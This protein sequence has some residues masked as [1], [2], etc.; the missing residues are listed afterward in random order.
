[1]G[2]AK[3]KNALMG[4]FLALPHALLTSHRYRALS[5]SAVKLLI[6]IAMQFDGKNNGDL[7]AAWKVMKSKGWR[8]EATLDRA[9]KELL[10]LGLIAQTRQGR[11]PN[12]C[13]LY[14][15]TWLPLNPSD[16]LDIGPA[17]FSSGEWAK[18]LA[19]E[20]GHSRTVP[21]TKSVVGIPRIATDS[22]VSSLVVA[23]EIV[24]IRDEGTDS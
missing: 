20:S 1:M 11:L 8:S 15:L 17:G 9:K 24:A 22:I 7:S 6:D 13:T 12:T 14:G 2:R 18:P 5:S 16:K 4:R 23:T 19:A 3:P 10:S 21:A